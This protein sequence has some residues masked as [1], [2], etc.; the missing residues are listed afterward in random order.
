MNILLHICCSTCSLEPVKRLKAGGNRFTGFWFN[1]N[2][3]PF[4]E[5]QLRLDSLKRLSEEWM[6][7]VH[8]R[9]DYRPEEYFRMFGINGEPSFQDLNRAD[10]V[11]PPA[12]D[13][14]RKCYRIRLDRT[15]AHARQEGFDGFST[16][17]LISPYQDFDAI[18]ALGHELAEQYNVAFHLE[19]YRHGFR[20]AMARSKEMGL[21]RQK[22]CGCLFSKS[23]RGMKKNRL[24]ARGQR[25]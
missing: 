5:Y 21:Y 6:F 22:Y 23:E 25:L 7:D 3:H 18:A 15:A 4:G 14:C 13:R 8:Y 19:D 20:Y 24:E 17:L 9:E 1:P 12:P 10:F 2:I 11:I 16:T